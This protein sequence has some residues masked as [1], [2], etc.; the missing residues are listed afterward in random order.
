MTFTRIAIRLA[1][2]ASVAPMQGCRESTGPEALS[3]QF[4]V[5]ASPA[6][7]ARGS[8]LLVRLTNVGDETVTYM[9]C[10][11]AYRQEGGR[12]MAA[13]RS[14]Q[15]SAC[16]D[17]AQSVAPGETMALS[18]GLA[19][20]LTPGQYRFELSG[21]ERGGRALARDARTSNE[22]TVAAQQG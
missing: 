16:P 7:A 12:W 2:L 4:S 17:V 9:P 11:K 22:V 21:A 15:Q 3:G 8:N 10:F 20:D 13:P 14:S 18:L 1:T 5:E 6:S 19:S